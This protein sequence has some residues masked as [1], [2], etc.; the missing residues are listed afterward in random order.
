MA[1]NK[2]KKFITKKVPFG[3]IITEYVKDGR[4]Y[5]YHATKGWRSYRMPK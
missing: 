4:H 3:R 1:Y 2:H 5:Q